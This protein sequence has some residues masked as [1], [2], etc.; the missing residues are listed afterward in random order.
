MLWFWLLTVVTSDQQQ[1]KTVCSEFLT[2]YLFTL[3]FS[4]QQRKFFLSFPKRL[5]LYFGINKV[6]AV[7]KNTAF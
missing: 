5:H 7:S 3:I 2:F 1:L 4:V 6:R